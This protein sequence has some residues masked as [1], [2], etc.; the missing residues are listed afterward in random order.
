MYSLMTKTIM[1]GSNL[2]PDIMHAL[3]RRSIAIAADDESVSWR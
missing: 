1:T 3:M 2:M